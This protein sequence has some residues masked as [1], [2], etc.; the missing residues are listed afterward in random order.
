MVHIVRPKTGKH[1]LR[2]ILII[3]LLFATAVHG[4]SVPVEERDAARAELKQK[5]QELIAAVVANNP[6]VQEEIDNSVGYLAGTAFA[7][8]PSWWGGVPARV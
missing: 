1:H 3:G 7:A 6:E 4:R 5:A 8:K 2:L